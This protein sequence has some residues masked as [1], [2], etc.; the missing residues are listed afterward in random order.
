MKTIRFTPLLWACAALALMAGGI[1]TSV[2]ANTINMVDYNGPSDEVTCIP[3]CSGFVGP[4]ATGPITTSLTMADNYPQAGSPANELARL[5]ELLDLFVP[6]RG[7]IVDVNKID[8]ADNGFT[9]SLQYFSIKKQ[10]F[11]WFFENTSGGE[12]TV[13]LAGD[14]YSH[15]TEYGPELTV[16]PVPAAIWLF[17]TALI[18]FVGMSRK[19]KLG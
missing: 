8:I 3:Q 19:T 18:G 13:S 15:W 5:N 16:V 1:S 14:D 2:S 12:V 7:P 6:A 4:I 9:T 17:G 11:L 10:T